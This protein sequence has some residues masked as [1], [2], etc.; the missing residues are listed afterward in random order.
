M[1]PVVRLS[2]EC[3][4]TRQGGGPFK[5]FTVGDYAKTKI[6]C[7]KKTTDRHKFVWSYPMHEHC[8]TLFDHIFGTPCTTDQLRHSLGPVLH[9]WRKI[10]RS[11]EQECINESWLWSSFVDKYH[12]NFCHQPE[13]WQEYETK[14]GSQDGSD[15]Y[16]G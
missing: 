1:I 8:I 9:N 4:N 3:Y 5:L 13:L 6:T 7:R 11:V 12:D 14:L 10:L 16:P 15:Q 2:S